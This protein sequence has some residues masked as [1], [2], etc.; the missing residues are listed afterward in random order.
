[1]KQSVLF[2]IALIFTTLTIPKTNEHSLRK[3]KEERK[4]TLC[5][6]VIGLLGSWGLCSLSPS[7]G[8]LGK[9][10]P[11][12]WEVKVYTWSELA[13]VIVLP[14]PLPLPPMANEE[15]QWHPQLRRLPHFPRLARTPWEPCGPHQDGASLAIS[16]DI[17]CPSG[18]SV[19]GSWLL[20]RA[21]GHGPPPGPLRAGCK[22]RVFGQCGNP[23]F[24]HSHLQIMHEAKVRNERKSDPFLAVRE[25]R[26]KGDKEQKDRHIFSY[27]GVSA[28]L[29]SGSPGL[30]GLYSAILLLEI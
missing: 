9:S 15:T 1:M 30:Y 3:K 7:T 4:D 21:G 16:N 10:P 13:T 25:P 12:C 6:A 11:R 20:P 17:V 28:K 27:I 5:S 2:P 14:T 24:T 26:G 19:Q 29:R 23:S 22:G 18:Q 8:S